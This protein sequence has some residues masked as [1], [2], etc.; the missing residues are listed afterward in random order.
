MEPA[1]PLEPAAPTDPVEPLEPELDP[2]DGLDAQE[3]RTTPTKA[4]G[5]DKRPA[6][7]SLFHIETAF[8]ASAT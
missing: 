8:P 3:H 2:F 1:A 5:Q 6:R 7:Q 4:R